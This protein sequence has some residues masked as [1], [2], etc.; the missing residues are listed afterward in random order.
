M[1]DSKDL[2]EFLSHLPEN[3]HIAGEGIHGNT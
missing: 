2:N 3:F 1:N